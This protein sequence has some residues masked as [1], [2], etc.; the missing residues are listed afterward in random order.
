M[1]FIPSKIC[2]ATESNSDLELFNHKTIL[3][4]K[5]TVYLCYGKTCKRPV[6]SAQ[7]ILDLMNE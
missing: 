4:D 1:H 7:E 3:H 2:L 6:F 5:T